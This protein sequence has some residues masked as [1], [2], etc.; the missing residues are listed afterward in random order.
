MFYAN[1]PELERQTYLPSKLLAEVSD[2]FTDEAERQ[3]I[4]ISTR[5]DEAHCSTPEIQVD[6]TMIM[7]AI[8]VLIRNAIDAIGCQGTIILSL[9]CDPENITIVVA[10]SGPGLSANAQKHAFDPYFS[11]REAGRGLGLGLCRAYRIA[12]LHEGDISLESGPSGCVATLA[13]P[14]KPMC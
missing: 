8:R 12:K 13:I 9:Q 1:P 10:D 3:A 11:G 14:V 7:E 5:N 6:G 2:S 4:Q